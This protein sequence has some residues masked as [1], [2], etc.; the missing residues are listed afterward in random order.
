[1]TMPALRVR[2]PSGVSAA[3]SALTPS[4]AGVPEECEEEHE[5]EEEEEEPNL[6]GSHGPARRLCAGAAALA[7]GY[8]NGGSLPPSRCVSTPSSV[9]PG[10]PHHR[11][12][13]SLFF[14]PP[15]TA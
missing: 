12:R 2:R 8:A 10:T 3:G 13:P 5:E 14:R 6:L 15:T 11:W 9:R 4:S 1:M 7:G